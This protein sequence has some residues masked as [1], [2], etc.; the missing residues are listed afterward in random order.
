MAVSDF[1]IPD[2][3]GVLLFCVTEALLELTED[4]CIWQ[5]SSVDERLR[6]AYVQFS[7]ACRQHAVRA[8]AQ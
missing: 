6:L 2:P 5:A 3:R 7:Q 4:D 8:L 1:W